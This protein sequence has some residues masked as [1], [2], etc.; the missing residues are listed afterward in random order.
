[1][2]N[3]LRFLSHQNQFKMFN[4]LNWLAI[5]EQIFETCGFNVIEHMRSGVLDSR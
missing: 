1:M 2:Y 5:C 3:T 4:S